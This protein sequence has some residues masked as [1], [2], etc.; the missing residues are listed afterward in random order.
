MPELSRRSALLLSFGVLGAGSLGLAGS[1]DAATPRTGL[2]V[3]AR[4]ARSPRVAGPLRSHYV[5]L[6]GHPVT[7]QGAGSHPLRLLDILDLLPA[8]TAHD[9][10]C[11]NLIFESTGPR[12]PAEG[13]YRLTARGLA[14]VS[15]YLSPVGSRPGP[16]RLQALVNRAV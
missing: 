6:V 10:H 14:P 5:H 8:R 7:A 9:E 15:L 11:F 13:L 12:E 2:H 1:A 16:S 3:P 4:P